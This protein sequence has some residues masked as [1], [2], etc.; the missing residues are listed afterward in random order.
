MARESDPDGPLILDLSAEAL[1]P[2]PSPADAPPVDEPTAAGAAVA[3]LGAGGGGW[4]LAARLFWGGAGLLAALAL[5]L[6]ADGLVRGLM[7]RADWLGWLALGLI[8]LVLLA[9]GLMALAELAALARLRRVDALRAAAAAAR[10]T[11]STARAAEALA[12]LDA[13]YAGRPE[14][15][16]A[17][18]RLAA[19]I[20]DTPDAADRLAVAERLLMAPLDA[21]AE[22]EVRRAARMVAAATALIPLALVDVASAL[23]ANL[24][25]IRRIAAIYGGRAGWLGSWRLL[26]LVAGHLVATGL[27]A[28]GDDVLGPL[29]GGGALAKISR[30]F[31]EGL[32]NGAL[33]ARIGVAAIEVC[34]PLPFHE[35]RRP[36]ARRMV[37]EALASWGREG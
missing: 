28:A 33:T 3:R 36:S 20:P 7:A 32:V 17:R 21:E 29:L 27:V 1:P 6:A 19:A 18:E 35:L 34:R 30:R 5:G 22:A 10:E 26:K 4:S 11:A 14:L 9:L 15:A 13:F 8:G 37:T 12:A 25:M 2:A 31:G 16:G 23:T 24:R